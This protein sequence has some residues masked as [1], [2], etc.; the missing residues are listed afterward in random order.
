[1]EKNAH[2]HG[3]D[4]ITVAVNGQVLAHIFPNKLHAPEGVRFLNDESEQFQVG[5]MERP[6]G[7]LVL[8]HTHPPC[9]RHLNGNAEFVLV[10]RGHVRITF[11]DEEWNQIAVHELKD[12]DSTLIL[13]GGHQLEM[14][15]ETRM[16]EVKQG[17]YMGND[18]P[19]IFRDDA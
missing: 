19:K 14:L 5:L 6:A 10:Q 7:H 4:P 2:T 17:P 3:V 11:Y 13:R 18:Y 16:F 8:A 15:E 1:M 9:K 12:G